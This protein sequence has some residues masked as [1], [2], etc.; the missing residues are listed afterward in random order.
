MAR[1]LVFGNTAYL[2][3]FCPP[4]ELGTPR[5]AGHQFDEVNPAWAPVAEP[6]NTVVVAISWDSSLHSA[7]TRALSALSNML[8]TIVIPPRIHCPVPPSSGMENCAMVPPPVWM[9]NS[10]AS[11]ASRDSPWR[12]AISVMA[13][14][15]SGVTVACI[16]V[17]LSSSCVV[18]DSL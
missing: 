3:S 7:S 17:N 9:A 16:I 11:T 15:A 5:S 6:R 2:V 13:L 18:G 12:W 4:A 14:S 8:P 1:R 10:M